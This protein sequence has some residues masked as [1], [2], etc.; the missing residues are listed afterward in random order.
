MTN[1]IS[2]LERLLSDDVPPTGEVTVTI[3]P[4]CAALMELFHDEGLRSELDG[5]HFFDKY[6]STES[7]D[8]L[9]NAIVFFEKAV[10]HTLRNNTDAGVRCGRLTM[11]SGAYGL[12]YER[13]GSTLDLDNAIELFTKAIDLMADSHLDLNDFDFLNSLYAGLGRWLSRRFTLFGSS[14][15]LRKAVDA[16]EMAV[17]LTPPDSPYWPGRMD[18]L[19]QRL[20][21]RSERDISKEDLDQAIKCFEMA[22]DAGASLSSHEQDIFLSNLGGSLVKKFKFNGMVKDLDRSVEVLEEALKKPSS[23]RTTRRNILNNLATAF[24]E[25]YEHHGTE[26]DL[27]RAIELQRTALDANPGGPHPDGADWG[28]KGNL[29]IWLFKRA[30]RTGS[31]EDSIRS[32]HSIREAIKALPEDHTSRPSLLMGLA[33]SLEA[34]SERRS[35]LNDLD[36]A[37]DLAREAVSSITPGHHLYMNFINDLAG[38]LGSRAKSHLRS[39][40]AQDSPE[41]R[42]GDP[43]AEAIAIMRSSISATK[44]WHINRPKWL[45]SLGSLLGDRFEHSSSKSLD[46]I[47]DAIKFSRQAVE[48]TP[49]ES[50]GRPASLQRLASWLIAR[51]RQ[52][53]M[54]ED[55]N[56]ALDCLREGLKPQNGVPF[57]R[58]SMAG[59]AAEILAAR[60][61]WKEADQFL[62]EAISL[63]PSMTPRSLQHIDNQDML[64]KFE[65]LASTA[66]AVALN[67]GKSAFDALKLLELGRGVI[68]SLLLDVRGDISDLKEQHPFLATEFLALRNELDSVPDIRNSM[69]TSRDLSIWELRDRKRRQTEKKFGDLIKKIQSLSGFRHFCGTPDEVEL[70]AAAGA[71]PIAVINVSPH[72]CDAFLIEKDSIRV[73][74]LPDLAWDEVLQRRRTL[75]RSLKGHHIDMAALLEW[76]W[77]SITRPCLDALNFTSPISSG[78]T[79]EWPRI[80]WIPTGPLIQFPIHAAGRDWQAGGETVL[81][82]VMSSYAL[83]L[84]TLIHGRRYR[85]PTGPARSSNNRALL[86]AMSTTPGLERD[87]RLRWAQKEVDMLAALCPELNLQAIT[88]EPRKDVILDDLQSCKV[89]HFAGHGQSYPAEP[90]QSCLLLQ[91]WQTSPL[92]VAEF[93]DSRPRDQV[94]RP[95]LGYLSACS[96]GASDEKGL[97]DE[98][99]HLI[100]SLQLAGF[101]HV[102]GTLWEVS[103]QHCVKVA[104]V[105]YKTL[106]DRG[107]TDEA[108]CQGLHRATRELRNRSLNGEVG[109]RKAFC[110][111]DGATRGALM[112]YHWVPYVHFGV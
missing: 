83:S 15:D 102:I 58:V 69:K 64:A 78:N 72:R 30:M 33:T 8:D 17:N 32:V 38:I 68:A 5:Q 34:L 53:G 74:E 61:N 7:A 100:S 91:D 1:H 11:L 44:A 105:F 50:Y 60:S 2:Q 111:D 3:S 46:D 79:A 76:L 9:E 103:D 62:E 41:A 75:Q 26:R 20:G 82:R 101:R 49:R 19:G 21:T 40:G 31:M 51:Y 92:T 43:F 45:L 80:W 107:M 85:L 104:E 37:V 12:R 35:S 39:P 36:E 93:R 25:I 59:N 47:N 106:R 95:F 52:I 54:V 56:D 18:D 71:G 22:V 10:E 16:A 27:D 6:K 13:T 23:N 48:N 65:G 90:D 96:T 63:F 29:G 81:D 67:A 89:F 97:A 70:K 14:E 77:T 98:G 88:P 108:V 66:A 94:A 73:L 86:L 55:E 4:Q 99:I 109:H 57:A 87:G 28:G 24:G 110:I 84:R 42:S 112:D